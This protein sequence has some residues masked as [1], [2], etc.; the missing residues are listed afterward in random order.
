M[1]F[2]A[3]NLFDRKRIRAFT[4]ADNFSRDC[5][6]I[7]SDCSIKDDHPVGVI[8]TVEQRQNRCLDRIKV[9]SGSWL[10]SKA[11][12]K[13][14]YENVVVLD[15]SWLGPATDNPFI[16]S[17]HSGVLVECLNSQ[18]LQLLEDARKQIEACFE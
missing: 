11:T 16:Q 1:N 5:L 17:L 9:E 4:I 15:F 13:W 8:G 3:Q 12:D 14:A 7:D 18:R 6:A 10:I 2:C